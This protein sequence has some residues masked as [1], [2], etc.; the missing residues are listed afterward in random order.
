MEQ[1]Q[2]FMIILEELLAYAGAFSFNGDPHGLRR[3]NKGQLRWG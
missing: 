1:M 2:P 3:Q